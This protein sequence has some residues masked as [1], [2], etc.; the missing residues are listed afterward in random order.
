MATV[1]VRVIGTKWIPCESCKWFAECVVPKGRHLP[2][3]GQPVKIV[4]ECE[5]YTKKGN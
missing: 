3:L 4:Y 2:K 1:Q 5:E